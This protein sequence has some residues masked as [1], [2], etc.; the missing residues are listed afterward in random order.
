MRYLRS[1]CA[2]CLLVV[3]PAAYPQQISPN[4]NPV[5]NKITVDT[6][7]ANDADAFTNDGEIAITNVGTLTN[8]GTL[9]TKAGCGITTR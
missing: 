5:G 1:L 3:S 7:S 9:N 4:P 2:V 8:G 6:G